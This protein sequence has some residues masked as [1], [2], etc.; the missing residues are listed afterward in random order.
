MGKGG[1]YYESDTLKNIASEANIEKHPLK[2]R[3]YSK[4]II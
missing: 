2:E 1:A 3:I 4:S